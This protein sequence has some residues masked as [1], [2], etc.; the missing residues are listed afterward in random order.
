MT[1]SIFLAVLFVIG[2]I[3]IAFEDAIKINKAA[4]SVGM[5][6][7]LWLLILTH[8]GNLFTLGKPII[9]QAFEAFMPDEMA[10]YTTLQKATVYIGITLE[11]SLGNVSSTLFFVLAS[12]AIVEILDSHGSFKVISR[13]IRTRKK[14]LLTW[15][16][17][18]ITFILSALLGNIATVIII[19][20]VM[21]K[22]I[23][24]KNERLKY[25]CLSII[26]ANAGGCWSPIGD[27]TTLLLWSGKNI[28]AAHQVTHLILP[29]LVTAVVPTAIVS[30]SYKKNECF[31][32]LA[33]EDD[34]TL[35]AYITPSLQ[36]GLLVIGLLSLL[37]V[38]FFQTLFNMPSYMTVLLGL[39]ILWVITDMKA[40]SSHD[41]RAAAHKVSRLFSHLDLSTVFFFLGILM[42]VEALK[43]V[44]CLTVM[45][46]GLNS[47][48][49][50]TNF[51]A[52]ILGICSSFL[53]NVA[54]VA[55]T[56][57][58]YPLAAEG[59]F[60][61]DSSFWTFLAYCAVTGGS[62]LIIGSASGVTAMGLEKIKFGYYLKKF[63]PLAALGYAAG[64]ATYLLLIQ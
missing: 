53:D 28:S 32:E 46:D 10:N 16:F 64:A 49:S 6:I 43:Q 11:R 19:I 12:M 25:A 23:P 44:G 37:T 33:L 29:A 39:V 9:V 2:I 42:S 38:P 41:P 7:I 5:C 51:I 56:M 54:L 40:A 57:G 63:T 8:L 50:E 48:I 22:I 24:D 3:L 17:A 62:I 47:M 31:E 61:A 20:A 55:A 35:P 36:R 52:L 58:M 14:R 26:A 15:E 21:R 13:A 1:F 60:M 27:V 30:L 34:N 59:T 45:A 4:I 18:A